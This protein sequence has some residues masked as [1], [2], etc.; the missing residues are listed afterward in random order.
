MFDMNEDHYRVAVAPLTSTENTF[1]GRFS[2]SVRDAGYQV[3][4][5]SWKRLR[6][7]DAVIFHWPSA[8]FIASNASR[9]VKC[10][11]QIALM[12]AYGAL[13]G[14]K[15]V[16]VVHNI[17]PHDNEASPPWLIRSFLSALDG[18]VVFSKHSINLVD[19][20][21][22]PISSLPV[23]QTVHGHYKDDME[24]PAKRQLAVGSQIN[25][26]FFGQVRQYKGVELLANSVC[27]FNDPRL[28][29][30][31]AG[32]GNDL[33]L[34]K[35]LSHIAA[36]NSQIILDIRDGHLSQSALER[37]VDSSHVV[38]LPYKDILNSGS[39]LFALSRNRAVVAP[40]IGSLPELQE[41]VGKNW[42][43]L[44]DGELTLNVLSD[45]KEWLQARD[46]TAWCDLSAFNWAEVG[47]DVGRFLA[48]L[49]Q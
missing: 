20:A 25:T 5:F 32:F 16:W 17:R 9:I 48:T 1:V 35:R 47:G 15:F 26:L 45:M 4:S 33:P 14:V 18:I 37:H 44:Y 39:A 40:R 49:R 13:S 11:A 43:Y 8:F 27:E 24:Q 41:M 7:V 19:E 29:L 22:G 36:S 3:E 2:E 38:I 12:K 6:G 31:I 42:L 23:L 30:T 10:V 46:T 28:K 34:V 21:Y